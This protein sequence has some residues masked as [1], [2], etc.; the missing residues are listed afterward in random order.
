MVRC[1]V[2]PGKVRTRDIGRIDRNGYLY[3]LDRADDMI[4]SGGFNIRP[5]ELEIVIEDHP[6]FIEAAVFAIPHERWGRR[7]WRSAASNRTPP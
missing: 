4:V 3:V 5:A 6:Q 2:M 7:P 1:T